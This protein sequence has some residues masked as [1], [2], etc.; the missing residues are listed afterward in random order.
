MKLNLGACDRSVDDYLSV[1]IVP[2]ADF[3]ADLSLRWPWEDSSIDRIIAYDIIEHIED[4]IHF[5][6]E[7]HRVM[8]PG[9]QV[10]IETPNAARGAGFFQ[11]PTHKS[12]WCLNSFQ[13][14]EAGSFAVQRLAKSYGITARFKII[15]LGELEYQDAREAVWKIRAILECVK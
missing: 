14:Y 2:P 5:M 15:E 8:K 11:D 6:N 4:R 12:P 10:C 13:Y 7:L 1:D 9:A 3:V